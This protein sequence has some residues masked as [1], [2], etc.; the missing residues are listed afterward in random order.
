[1]Q[2]GRASGKNFHAEVRGTYLFGDEP[3]AHIG[4]APMAF[5]A[6]GM[7]EFD[8]HLASDV[9]IQGVAGTRRVNVWITDGPWFVTVGGGMRYQLSLR[10]AFTAAA[11][12]NFAFQGNGLLPT[13]GP[14]VGFEYGL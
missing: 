1:V 9:M 14:E 6:G 12:V 13:F 5:V 2:D 7:A 4:F 8:G 11:R 10:A 3:L